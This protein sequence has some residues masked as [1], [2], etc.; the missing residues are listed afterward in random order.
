M[1]II[2]TY[3]LLIK[4]M[5]NFISEYI[6]FLIYPLIFVLVY[7]VF[8]RYFMNS[9]T[10]WAH[11]LSAY[12]YSI[13][14]L[15]GGVYALTAN[16]HIKI[17]IFYKRMPEKYRAILDLFTWLLFFAFIIAL[18]RQSTEYS[19]I[20]FLRKETAFSVWAPPIWPLK[21]IIVFAA[22]L[23]FLE[24]IS[25]M[26]KNVYLILTGKEIVLYVDSKKEKI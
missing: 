5:N 26:I 18:L 10:V 2:R 12:I 25:I 21:F 20:S 9:P 14:F 19:Y 16:E 15:I 24:G 1:K 13:L 7:E 3:I 22:F 6:S 17:D 4:K 23:M 8:M 11:E